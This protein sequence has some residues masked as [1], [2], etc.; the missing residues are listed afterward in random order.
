MPEGNH[1]TLSGLV[2]AEPRDTLTPLTRAWY[3]DIPQCLAFLQELENEPVR[4]GAGPM[5]VRTTLEA[6]HAKRR[7]YRMRVQAG[8]R[9]LRVEGKIDL[10]VLLELGKSNAADRGAAVTVADRRKITPF[11]RPLSLVL[12]H[13]S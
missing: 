12:F 9:C 1:Y 4:F 7:F 2:Q 5:Y 8:G 11:L 13:V 6:D 3:I 10:D